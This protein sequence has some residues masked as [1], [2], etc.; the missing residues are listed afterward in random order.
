NS[1][2]SLRL[3][4]VARAHGVPAHLIERA[5]DIR[6][7]WLENVRGLGLTAS[8]SAP[9]IL[10]QEGID[11]ARRGFGTKDVRQVTTATE[12]LGCPL[13]TEL[14]ALLTPSRSGAG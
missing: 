13:P 4:E 8:A 1:S 14:T 12:H 9:E 10:V 7:E 2:N 3:C 5:A 11:P 6:P